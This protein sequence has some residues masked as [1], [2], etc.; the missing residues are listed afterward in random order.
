MAII[1]RQPIGG[2][3]CCDCAQ[4]A[5]P[6][7]CSAY[8]CTMECEYKNGSYILCGISEY[9]SP[10]TPPKKFRRQDL[11]GGFQN[12]DFHFLAPTGVCSGTPPAIASGNTTYTGACQYNKDTCGVVNTGLEN[13]GSASGG[14]CVLPG[15]TAS[16]SAGCDPFSPYLTRINYTLAELRLSRTWTYVAGCTSYP[17]PNGIDRLQFGESVVAQLSDEDTDADAIA[18]ANAVITDW[19]AGVSCE[20]FTAFRSSRGAGSFSATYR[21]VRTRM[22]ISSL[23]PGQFYTAEF[24]IFG[25]VFGA[26]DWI[27]QYSIFVQFTATHAIETTDWQELTMLEGM[28]TKAAV[29]NVVATP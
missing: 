19:S 26:T 20:L 16:V 10:S 28:E 3:A 17:N 23:T 14:A 7:G 22:T 6:C 24:K 29:C 21:S 12:C 8:A 15:I 11:S 13:T 27:Y 25:R 1:V 4:Q 5:D 18:R 9:T 2:G